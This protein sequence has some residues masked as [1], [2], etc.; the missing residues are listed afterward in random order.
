[1]LIVEIGS[2]LSFYLI[3]ISMILKIVCFRSLLTKVV[4]GPNQ[5]LRISGIEFFQAILN[6]DLL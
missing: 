6:Y 2:F 3:Q 4:H 5:K 1:M